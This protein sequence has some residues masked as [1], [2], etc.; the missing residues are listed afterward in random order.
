MEIRNRQASGTAQFF[1]SIGLP[2][3]LAYPALA[4]EVGGDRSRPR[5]GRV[6]QRPAV[7]RAARRSGRW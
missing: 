2:G 7:D 3:A 4:D 5:R 6:R 1:A